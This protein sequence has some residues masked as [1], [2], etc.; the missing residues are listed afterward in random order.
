M[1]IIPRALAKTSMAAVA[2]GALAL[3]SATPA[4]ARDR[5]NGIDAGEIIAGAVILGGIAA[6]LSS[7]SDRDRYRDDYRSRDRNYR[8]RN[9]RG[10]RYD[11]RRG[12]G[13]RAV[14]KCVRAVE[15]DARRAGYRYANVT[16]IR[17]IDRE[18]RGW[19][20]E[21]RLEV[22]GQRGYRGDR[23]YRGTV[24]SPQPRRSWSV[25]LRCIAG[26]G[27]PHRL[28]WYPRASL[29][30]ARNY[31]LSGSGLCKPGPL[32]FCRSY[33]SLLPWYFA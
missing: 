21:G 10:G 20:V 14:Q 32:N 17:D 5:D 22:D 33:R 2:A 31:R 1:K 24:R 19:E 3:T 29:G 27:N 6:V 9:Y 26:P 15:Q 4:F 23:N 7:G 12:N 8:D 25:H 28:R 30:F 13:Q 11:A 18:R 16:Q